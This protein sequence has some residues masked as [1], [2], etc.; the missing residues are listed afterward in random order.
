MAWLNVHFR[1]HLD[2][3]PH[4]DFRCFSSSLVVDEIYATMPAYKEPNVLTYHLYNRERSSCCCRVRVALALKNIPNVV[5]HD[6]DMDSGAHMTEGYR[7]LNP[8]GAVPTFIREITSPTG[9]VKERFV[10]TQS[11]AILE[12]LVEKFPMMGHPLMPDFRYQEQKAK[13]REMVAIVS[14]DIF[15]I[16]IARMRIVYGRSGT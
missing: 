8:S 7:V 1:H 2:L 12:Y 5:L 6:V 14:Q 4:Y 9:E 16:A 15:P 3:Y 11:T 10:L 13:I